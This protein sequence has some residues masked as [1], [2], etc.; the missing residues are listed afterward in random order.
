MD[1]P[2]S[3]LYQSSLATQM[4]CFTLSH[5]LTPLLFNCLPGKLQCL[6]AHL[7]KLKGALSQS[8]RIHVFAQCTRQQYHNLRTCVLHAAE[9]SI[10][11]TTPNWPSVCVSRFQFRSTAFMP[12][13]C[14]A[15]VILSPGHVYMPSLS[16]S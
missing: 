14:L 15:F 5:L 7:S 3:D 2:Q 1:P 12:R 4:S 13:L 8:A 11:K 10:L 9:W 16:P 6:V